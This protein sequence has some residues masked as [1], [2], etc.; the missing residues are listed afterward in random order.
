[1]RSKAG[2]IAAVPP[3]PDQVNSS[4]TGSGFVV[5][6]S[7]V[8]TVKL[9]L[10]MGFKSNSGDVYTPGLH[11]IILAGSAPFQPWAKKLYEIDGRHFVLV[12]EGEVIGYASAE[13]GTSTIKG[14]SK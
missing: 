5:N 14:P 13:S 1:M 11:R 12:P 10:V 7:R 4:V 3:V 2:F 6:D 8:K 9:D